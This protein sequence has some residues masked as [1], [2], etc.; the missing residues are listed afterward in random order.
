MMYVDLVSVIMK[1]PRVKYPLTQSNSATL[2]V[3]NYDTK[4]STLDAH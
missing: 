3:Y 4:D 2:L 1:C